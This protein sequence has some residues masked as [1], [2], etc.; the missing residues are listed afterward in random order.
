M[1]PSRPD[2]L[3]GQDGD[4][5]RSRCSAAPGCALLQLLEKQDG[6]LST[7]GLQKGIGDLEGDVSLPHSVLAKAGNKHLD[8]PTA[9]EMDRMTSL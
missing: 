8:L 6:A 9:V 1:F 5:P 4:G 2:L 3:P 7:E